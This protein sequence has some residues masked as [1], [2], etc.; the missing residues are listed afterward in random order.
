MSLPD[1]ADLVV[2]GTGLV[3]SL[4]ACAAAFHGKSVIVL[5]DKPYYGGSGATLNLCSFMDWYAK[6]AA[7]QEER[8]NR[9]QDSL[10]HTQQLTRIPSVSGEDAPSQP[11]DADRRPETCQSG[12][13]LAVMHPAAHQ[14]ATKTETLPCNAPSPAH[15]PGNNVLNADNM[16]H[17]V[18]LNLD[19]SEIRD[20]QARV[21]PHRV[22][23]C[24]K[25]YC[26]DLAHQAL[27]CTG[28]CVEAIRKAGLHLYIDFVPVSDA[29]VYCSA[30]SSLQVVPSSISA[31]HGMTGLSAA[32]KRTL[33]LFMRQVERAATGEAVPL[34]QGQ[35]FGRNL[36]SCKLPQFMQDAL[37]YGVLQCQSVVHSDTE[38]PGASALAVILRYMS[39]ASAYVVGQAP[40]I[41]PCYGSGEIAQAAI[42]ACCVH[43]GIAALDCKAQ[44]LLSEGDEVK[45]V[46]LA[47]GHVVRCKAVAVSAAM[48]CGATTSGKTLGG[49]QDESLAPS[50]ACAGQGVLKAST[51]QTD[52]IVTS[53]RSHQHPGQYPEG[54]TESNM[55]GCRVNQDRT[56]PGADTPAD[57]EARLLQLVSECSEPALR[58]RADSTCTNEGLLKL[59]ETRASSPA[60]LSESSG[61]QRMVA[62]GIVLLDS[63]LLGTTTNCH[64]TIPPGSCNNPYSVA[65]WQCNSTLH[66]CPPGHVLLYLSTCSCGVSAKEILQPCVLALLTA[67][68]AADLGR[69]GFKAQRCPEGSTTTDEGSDE[70]LQTGIGDVDG[71]D[72]GSSPAVPET[73]APVASSGMPGADST[74]GRNARAGE[75]T[76]NVTTDKSS[77]ESQ[78]A[79][80]PPICCSNCQHQTGKGCM[81]RSP[82]IDRHGCASLA[83][84]APTQE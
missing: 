34:F 9:P 47:G 48:L 84:L 27:Q 2:I 65:V 18:H 12:P 13:P 1:S 36:Q 38:L 55:E 21:E 46:C 74:C 49:M 24:S 44:A 82:W 73:D 20:V 71:G 17:I 39:Q 35:H 32:D 54:E 72:C 41:E 52:A 67:S 66:A 37:L 15:R 16:A 53:N 75:V 40:F 69:E 70:R 28:Q 6:N 81:H 83:L 7:A 30:D 78:S 62:R 26:I 25:D 77:L 43:G 60:L 42:R 56:Q 23:G 51:S 10:T 33:W 8:Q 68:D 57:G 64:F 45:G 4:L 61:E 63:P 76:R 14:S 59:A 11:L 80:P 79:P 29:Y 3:E 22:P 58:V 5:D 50:S 19:T 31:V